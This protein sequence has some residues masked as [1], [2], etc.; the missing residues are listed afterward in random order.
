[1]ERVKLNNLG[2]SPLAGICTYEEACRIGYDVDYN[3]NLLKRYVY[4]ETQ[5]NAIMAAHIADSPEWEVKCALSLHLWLDAEHSASVRKRIIEMREPPLHLDK[6]PDPK[7]QHLMEEVIRSANTLELLVGLYRVVKPELVRSM[8]QH[9]QQTNPLADQPTCRLLKFIVQEEAEMIVWGEEAVK[10]LIRTSEDAQTAEQWERHLAAY[11]QDAGGISGD[12]AKRTDSVLPDPR[13]DGKDF[14]MN[15]VPRRDERFSETY[16]YAGKIDEYYVDE[17]RP[18][19]ERTYALLY[20]RIREMDVPEWMGPIIYKTKGKPWEYYQ[21]LSRQLWDEA[22]HAM[23]G[24]VGLYQDGIPFYK[25]PIEFLSS[26]LLNTKFEPIEAHIALWGIE[27]SLMKKDTGKRWEW[28]IAKQSDNLLAGMFQDY[29]WADEVLHAQIGRKWLVTELGSLDQLQQRATLVIER[30]VAEKIE[31]SGQYE[32][33]QKQWWS[34]FLA[35]IR[36][37]RDEIRLEVAM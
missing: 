3:V 8:N 37:H 27:Q 31:I 24:E 9:L 19:D 13:N 29:D 14:E 7:L 12:L 6:V 11:L 2:I 30:F 23:L 28:I 32:H 36:K 20:K 17:Q 35:D 25:Y 15:G 1:M 10:A 26:L 16:N 22:R 5:L 34:E 33:Q 21:D 18:I 4:I